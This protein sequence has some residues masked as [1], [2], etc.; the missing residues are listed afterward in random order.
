MPGIFGIVDLTRGSI[1]AADERLDIVRR[2]AGAMC[3]DPEY[4]V[5]LV[6]CPALATCAGRVGWTDRH[7]GEQRGRPTSHSAL[8]TTGEPV[9]TEPRTMMAMTDCEAVGFG[10]SELARQMQDRGIDALNDTDGSFA[11]FFIDGR[12][13]T[14]MLFNDRYGMERLFVHAD[15]TR[16]LFSSEAKAILAVLPSARSVD[17][18][19]LAE[20]L[21]CGCTIG[22]RSLF[23]GIE[24]IAGGTALIFGLSRNVVRTRYFDRSEWEQLPTLS[25][26]RFVE[27]F[28]N[29][30]EHA[31]KDSVERPPNAAMSLTGGL[32]S[33]LIVACA[34][35]GPGKLPCYTF[36][37]M[38][39]PTMDVSVA[40]VVAAECRQLHHALTL[41]EPFLIEAREYLDQAVNISDGCLGLPGASELYLNR[42][43]RLVAPTRITGNWGGELMRGV[44]AFKFRVPA[45][46][47]LRP[48][49]RDLIADVGT[50]FDA[51]AGWN[52]L[53]YTLFRQL[54]HQGYGRYAVERSQV[55]MRSPFLFKDVVRSLYQAPPLARSSVDTVLT[56]LSRRPGL[57][58][59]PTDIG[60]L[61]RGLRAI[62][63]LR[64]GY[65]RA[66]VKAEYLTSH[67]A[68]R[69]MAPIT[70]LVPCLERA[71]LG[72]DKFQHF[73]LWTRTRLA[74]LVRDVLLHS[75]AEILEQWFDMKRVSDMVTEHIAGRAN[76]IDEIDKAMTL[77]LVARRY[78]SGANRD[79]L[80]PTR[81]QL[82]EIQLDDV[83][84]QPSPTVH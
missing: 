4:I 40:R 82:T 80:S 49:L 71:F 68:A 17:P 16:V 84:V 2:M 29:S 45:G 24:I 21:S 23:E 76:Y 6:S 70:T 79:A 31:V 66:M 37:S 46:D 59:I 42:Q 30:L 74:D 64:Q 34:N 75:R 38:Y 72:R 9:V 8:L 11:G 5:D 69:W 83:G 44:R 65:R 35:A 22:S 56:I 51:T 12:S 43:A 32:D 3:Y 57:I 47:F 39:R 73:R 58:D 78:E 14:C 33:R 19:A 10:A 53:S 36:A 77:V 62:R 50:T 52:P 7:A 25:T 28:T 81:Y 67:G 27:E 63:R 15:K 41:D 1:R 61:G 18:A 26:H 13:S 48:S 20:W 55:V 54:P 60:R